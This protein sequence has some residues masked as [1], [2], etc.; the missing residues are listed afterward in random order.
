MWNTVKRND[1]RYK[2]EL[3]RGAQVKRLESQKDVGY[4][5]MKLEK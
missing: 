4:A 3:L 5:T 1:V 2:M